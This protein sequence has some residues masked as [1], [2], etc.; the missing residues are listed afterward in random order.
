MPVSLIRR[1]IVLFVLIVVLIF[2]ASCDEH[3]KL[4]RY[5]APDNN[6]Y[7]FTRS[8][9]PL[10]YTDLKYNE[11]DIE[12]LKS[13]IQPQNL[14]RL[15]VMIYMNGSDLESEYGAAS[16]DLLE[17]EDACENMEL[18]NV[19]IFTGGA[20]RWLNGITPSDECAVSRVVDGNI[21]I[22]GTVGQCNMGDAGTLSAFI[23]FC[24]DIFP[25]DRTALI[26]WD[27]G[28]GTIAGYGDDEHFQDGNLTL[29]ELELAFEKAQLRDSPLEVLGFDACLMATV[30]TAVIA[31]EY[32]NYLVASESLEPE[33][34]WDY[35]FLKTVSANPD[36]TGDKFG[37]IVVNKYSDY[38]GFS[39]EEYTLS[40]TNLNYSKSVMGALGV[41]AQA[42]LN[43]GNNYGDMETLADMRAEV[44]SFGDSAPGGAECDMVDIYSL[45]NEVCKLFPAETDAVFGALGRAVEYH[46]SNTRTRTEGLSCY[47]I[48]NADSSS[49][50]ALHVYGSL[51]MSPEYT[52]FLYAFAGTVYSDEYYRIEP[53]YH[54][55]EIGGAQVSM[56]RVAE[57]DSGTMFSCAA[58]VNGE[59]AEI[60]FHTIDYDTTVV[61]GYR[62][63]DGWLIQKGYFPIT[64]NDTVL[65]G[66]NLAEILSGS[67]VELY[68]Q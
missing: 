24:G 7:G 20:N 29:R 23:K 30:E 64:E 54:S 48:Y 14:A 51:N 19:V 26:L 18:M 37:K 45:A 33:D 61:L 21:E 9:D 4:S 8:V 32:A 65:I 15:T 66:G 27:H 25:A 46:V 55:A 5:D 1:N 31:S 53:I 10:S 58:A 68:G 50:D 67:P 35:S 56:Y 49:D 6:D 39:L 57:P 17:I 52:E 42:M 22:I 63:N 43:Y 44:R 3:S 28:G 2:A 16:D 11:W 41:L 40:V 13:K 60:L 36:I 12:S 62:K 47:C 38:Y 34:G 59:A